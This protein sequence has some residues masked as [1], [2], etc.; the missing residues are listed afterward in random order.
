MG[1][2]KRRPAKTLRRTASELTTMMD[3]PLHFRLRY[4]DVDRPL[5]PKLPIM[6]AGGVVHDAARDLVARKGS[7]RHK[8]RVFYLTPE[9]FSGAVWGLWSRR[10]KK[11]EGE[12][13]RGIRWKSDDPKEQKR[14]FV[15]LASYMSR[16]M[17]GYAWEDGPDGQRVFR[18]V[19]RGYYQMVNEP[20][21]PFRVLAAEKKLGVLF[22]PF[23]GRDPFHLVGTMDLILRVEP[24]AEFPEGGVII[25]DVTMGSD[26]KYV[27]LTEYSLIFRL[28]LQQKPWFRELTGL[29][30]GDREEAVA[31]L[32][33]SKSKFYIFRRG[34]EDYENLTRWLAWAADV[35]VSKE[36]EPKPTDAVCG[37]CG[38]SYVCKYA[39]TTEVLDLKKGGAHIV[40]PIEEP[41]P[42]RIVQTG[43]KGLQRGRGVQ[44]TRTSPFPFLKPTLTLERKEVV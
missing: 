10:V 9:S 12:G 34:E 13:E 36:F 43:F 16:V 28:A 3:C 24:C 30:P 32:S 2:R 19:Q 20:R 15:G 27:Q 23:V 22:K 7:W 35:I 42:P 26:V 29:G 41:P 21:I 33:L 11:E 31:V 8:R 40:T 44:G 5:P 6:L 39:A 25:V 4:M 17:S 14:E 37:R 1:K 38:H 18:Q